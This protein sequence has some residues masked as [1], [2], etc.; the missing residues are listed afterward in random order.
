MIF[1]DWPIN[2][3][4]LRLLELI[5]CEVLKS[6]EQLPLIHHWGKWQSYFQ[7]S[8]LSS[9]LGWDG[10]NKKKPVLEQFGFYNPNHQQRALSH[11]FSSHSNPPASTAH[12]YDDAVQESG[13]EGEQ[14]T[15]R[16]RRGGYER[17]ERS[18]Q[19]RTAKARGYEEGDQSEL[20]LTLV[21]GHFILSLLEVTTEVVSVLMKGLI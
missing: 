19:R 15:R 10:E 7:R 11:P 13:Q 21:V 16:K 12:L 18:K 1:L 8:I 6:G 2:T 14:E 20:L 5:P 4:L 3:V 9:I 17:T